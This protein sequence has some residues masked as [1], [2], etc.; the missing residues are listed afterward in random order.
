MVKC[1][2]CKSQI[3]GTF[4]EKINGTYVNKKPVCQACQGKFSIKEIKEKVA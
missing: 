2:I 3:Q 1:T 4:L